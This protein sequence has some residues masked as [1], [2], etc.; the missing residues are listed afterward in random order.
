MSVGIFFGGEGLLS[1]PYISLFWPV[2]TCPLE[3]SATLSKGQRPRS[4]LSV[5]VSYRED[6][7][8]QAQLCATTLSG[9]FSG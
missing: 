6:S 1:S 3:A 9:D 2:G 5:L 4:S 8:P 7:V